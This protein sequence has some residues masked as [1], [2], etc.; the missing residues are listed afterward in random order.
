M[1][2]KR[3]HFQPRFLL[4]GFSSKR[5]GDI[6]FS[7]LYRKNT[8]PKE[9]DI[10]DIGVEKKFYNNGN[11][12]IDEAITEEENYLGMLV[13][14]LRCSKYEN[15][16]DSKKISLLI[17]HLEIRTRHL[18]ESFLDL[19]NILFSEIIKYFK[20]PENLNKFISEQLEKSINKELSAHHIPM[21]Q[22]AHKRSLIRANIKPVIE[23]Q[24]NHFL[25]FGI[26]DLFNKMPDTVKKGQL[27]AL[28]KSVIPKKRADEYS[29]LLWSLC[30]SKENYIFGD[31]GILIEIDSPKQFTTFW[32]KDFKI[33]KVFLPISSNC[34]LVGSYSLGDNI[35]EAAE[36]NIII[37]EHSREYFISSIND[38]KLMDLTNLIGSKSQI[39]TEEEIVKFC[40]S[41]FKF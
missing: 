8:I 15:T 37:A 34:L 18:R 12:K 20:K 38:A 40:E 27:K 1:S 14:K 39:F 10:R 26:N 36:L 21:Y 41:I 3:Q 9:V 4:K 16:L 33:K 13:N 19:S 24:F 31:F 17:S 7:W 22:R 2:G 11:S 6:Y 29:R 25:N 32:T 23:N 28:S 35:K 30:H 5:I